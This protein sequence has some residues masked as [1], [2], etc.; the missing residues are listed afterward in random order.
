MPG[1]IA[2]SH[3]DC[4]AMPASLPARAGVVV[5]GGG[6]VGCSI[7][8]HLARRGQDVLVLEQ[9]QL[10]AGTTWHAAGLVGQLKSTTSMTALAKYSADLYARLEDETGQAT[11]LRMTGSVSVASDPERWEE[12]LRGVAMAATLG[13]D[14]EV[15]E[16]Y[17]APSY[18][19]LL[20]A[21]DLVGA[22]FF[23]GDGKVNPVDTTLALARGARQAGA[24]IHEGV[25]VGSI[26]VDGGRAAGVA[27]DAGDVAADHV[28]IAAGMWSRRLA[29]DAGAAL[30]LQACEH[31][32]VVTEPIAGLSPDLPTLR[33]PTNYT[34]VKEEAGKL[35][36]GFFE[37]VAKPWAVDGIPDDFSFGTLPE[38]WDHVGPVF[39]RSIHRVPAL[40]E[41]GIH[42][43]FNGPE[44]FTP[45]GR[46]YLG[47]TPEVDG[48]WVAAGFNSVGIQS[49]G[50][51]GWALA[52]WIVEGSPPM[53]L[54]DVD[55]RRAQPHQAE[56]GYLRERASESLGLLY[57]MHWPFLQYET[58]RGVRISPLHGRLAAAGA[59]FGEL[60]GWERPNWFAPPGVEPQYEYSYGRQNWF[61]HS[62]AE[63]RAVRTGVGL[64]DQSSFAK[65]EVAGAGVE[66]ALQRICA[67]DVAVPPGTVVYTQWLNARGGIEADLTVTRLG[68]GR[69]LVVT[70]AATARRDLH[71]LLRHLPDQ[72]TVTDVTDD[73]PVLGVMGPLARRLLAELSG[74][75]LSNDG[76]PF[77][78][79][80]EIEVAGVPVRALRLSYV[81][82]L[83]W[84]LYVGRDDAVALYDAIRTA[85]E[86]FGLRLAGYHAMHSLR[87]ECGFVSW[88]HDVSDEDTPLQ[89]G[90]GFAVAWD[91]PGGFIGREALAG[92][93]GVPLSTRLVKLRLT[94]PGPLLYHDEPVYREGELVGRVTSGMFGH[95]VGAAVAL[96]S[97][98]HSGG[99]TRDWLAGGEWEVAVAAARV[100]AHLSLRPFYPARLRE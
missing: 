16:P 51:A 82:E 67:N 74:A 40:A 75:D 59:C 70:A 20:N 18:W 95:T 99:V 11:G 73:L 12:I 76:F 81:G 28:V 71:W 98:S 68:E 84:E 38:D 72:L 62:A 35:L 94:D 87:T 90:L 36:A 97:V 27:T 50:G 5:I 3:L 63:H 23:P 69:Y 33:D 31:F 55:I 2:R 15:L 78:T 52:E 37:P 42:T 77:G 6:I 49:A 66:G 46:Y 44:S 1:M 25:R 60:A 54:W 96:A 19:P 92:R 93:R 21:T 41:A 45:D 91:K 29:A 39:E 85:G 7:A 83:G 4:A 61:E 88:G 53:D 48:L 56:P 79:A 32:Y 8:Y 22:V 34:Y 65:F 89:A 30:P 64:F 100:G 86:A 14:A 9:S 10:T 26:L 24:V 43:F 17:E 47:E 13:V 80:Q 58:A 57:A